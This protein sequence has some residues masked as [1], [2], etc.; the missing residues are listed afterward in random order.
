VEEGVDEWWRSGG[1]VV[2]EGWLSGGGVVEEWWMRGW[3]SGGGV[4]VERRRDPRA[5]RRESY[6][7]LAVARQTRS[8]DAPR[9]RAIRAPRARLAVV[10][11]CVVV[12]L[13]WWCHDGAM[14]SPGGRCAGSNRRRR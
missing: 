4:V 3:L 9:H 14:I 2:D 1:G 6:L 8:G 13:S 7:L 10:D 5:T 12:A 11:V